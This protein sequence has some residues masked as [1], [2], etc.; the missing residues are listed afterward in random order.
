MDRSSKRERV[1]VSVAALFCVLVIT[2]AMARDAGGSQDAVAKPSVGKKLKKL[3]KRVKALEQG[4]GVLQQGQGVLEQGVSALQQEQGQPRPPSGPAGG[5]LSGTYPSPLIAGGAVGTGEL[6]SSIPA[7]RVGNS[8]NEPVSHLTEAILAFNTESYDT[9][10]MHSTTTANSHL[11]A[12]V[13]GIYAVS[14]QIVW[15]ANAAGF[16]QVT[17]RKN[18]TYVAQ[19]TTLNTGTQPTGQT[20]TAQVSLQAG[21]FVEARVVQNSGGSVNVFGGSESSPAFEIAWLAPGP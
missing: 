20:L 1:V 8:T 4:Q 11:T 7:A 21:D 2:I 6:S 19:E 14:V 5:D 3:T 9:A 16:R 15:D 13:N 17:L 10:D 12:P 18:G